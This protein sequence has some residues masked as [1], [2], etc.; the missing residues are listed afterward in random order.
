MFRAQPLALLRVWAPCAVARLSCSKDV[1][2]A[3]L[4]SEQPPDEDQ[5]MP[6]PRNIEVAV[7]WL[8]LVAAWATVAPPRTPTPG[9]RS[10]PRRRVSAVRTERSFMGIVS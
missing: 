8:I 3:L 6:E 9:A 10:A 2:V 5:L 1:Q 4:R 7:A